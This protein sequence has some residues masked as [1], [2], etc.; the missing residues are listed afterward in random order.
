[1]CVAK[2][3]EELLREREESIIYDPLNLQVNYVP[4]DASLLV[5]SFAVCV[6]VRH[7]VPCGIKVY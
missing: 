6:L 2:E 1:M 3:R 7:S 5:I 4:Q